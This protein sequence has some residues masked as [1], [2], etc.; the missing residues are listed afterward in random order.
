MI[1]KTPLLVLVLL[2]L[3]ACQKS[4]DT[5]TSVTSAEAVDMVATSLS[6][7]SNGLAVV[8][9]DVAVNAQAV[10]DLKLSCGATKSYSATH[11]N[12]AGSA[13]TYSNAF[14]YKYTLNCNANNMPDNITGSSSDNG[15]FDGPRLSST[16]TGASTFRIAGLTST[17]KAYVINGEYKRTGSFTSKVESKNTSNVAVDIVITNLMIDKAKKI[18][19]SGTAAVTITG[20]TVKKTSI[21]FSGSLTF[22]GDGKATITLNGIVYVI[23]LLTGDFV[24]K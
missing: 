17:A 24:K 19:T 4:S 7:N 15:A 10:F 9:S 6:A 8:S 1:L 18:I 13:N 22:T 11:Q 3:G 23:D 2:A 5:G 12:P 21:N 14:S 20:S 16:N